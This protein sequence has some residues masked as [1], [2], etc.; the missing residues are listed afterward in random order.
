NP[1]HMIACGDQV[2]A[3]Q[4]SIDGEVYAILERLHLPGWSAGK[5]GDP[6]QIAIGYQVFADQF[7]DEGRQDC[8][9]LRIPESIEQEDIRVQ[10]RVPPYVDAPRDPDTLPGRVDARPV[11]FLYRLRQS[12]DH[13][14]N[15]RLVNI[16]P[17][18]GVAWGRTGA[19]CAVMRSRLCAQFCR[20]C[21]PAKCSPSNVRPSA[22]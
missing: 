3:L 9:A 22:S 6:A 7:A 18:H 21:D 14:I 19:S 16:R 5:E 12:V 15:Q 2:L 11:V 10:R 13:G 1:A 17:V 4:Q 20:S 8:P